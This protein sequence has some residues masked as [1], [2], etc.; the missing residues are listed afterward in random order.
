[1]VLSIVIVTHDLAVVWLLAD[2]LMAVAGPSGV[3]KGTV[4]AA[5][6]ATEAHLR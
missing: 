4:M 5:M 3:G 6:V 1:M 2:R